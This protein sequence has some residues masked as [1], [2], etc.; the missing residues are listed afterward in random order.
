MSNHRSIKFGFDCCFPAVIFFCALLCVPSIANSQ[1]VF[2]VSNTNDSGTGSL[3]Q[4][5]T[6]ANTTSNADAN[7]PDMIVFDI[8]S[9]GVQTIVTSSLPAIYDPVIID[10]TTQPGYSGVPIV[11]VNGSHTAIA[12]S[13]TGGNT[14]IRGLVIEDF[15][16]GIRMDNFGANLIE[17]NYVGTDVTGSLDRAGGAQ[18]VSMRFNSHGNTVRNN[19]ISGFAEGITVQ[20]SENTI[21]DNFVGTDATGQF[22]IPNTIGIRILDDGQSIGTP[23]TSNLV[24]GNLVSG[25]SNIHFFIHGNA[26]GNLF[27]ENLVGTDLTGTLVLGNT[28]VAGFRIILALDNTFEG[29][30]VGGISRGFWLSGAQGTRIVENFIG[31]DV[32]GEIDLGNDYAITIQNGPDSNTE[33]VSNVIAYNQYAGVMIHNGTAAA[34]NSGNRIQANSIYSNSGLGIDLTGSIGV[35]PNDDGDPDTGP[36][37]LQ[38]FP[39]L[40]VVE[41]GSS[42]HVVGVL[43]SMPSQE[44]EIEFFASSSVDPSGH[45]EGERFLG[46]IVVNTDATN[47]ASFD[48]MLPEASFGV[49]WIT[50]TATDSQGNTSEFSASL[51]I[52]NSAPIANAGLDQFVECSESGNAVVALDGTG[53]FDPDGNSLDYLW[54]VPAGIVLDDET[55]ATPSGLFPLGITLVT[56]TVSDGKG[57]VGVN[58]VEITVT[59]EIP[60]EVSCTTDLMLLWPPNHQM[61]DVAVFIDATDDCSAPEDLILL[62]VTVSSSE[63]DDSNGT[64]DG[65]TIGDV[66]GENGDTEPVNV[67]SLFGYNAMTMSFEGSLSLRAERDGA[68]SGRTYTISA[69]LLDTANNLAETSCVIVVPHDRRGKK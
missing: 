22:A 27:T 66:N 39:I 25:N 21:G 2:T 58:D 15:S 12:F 43:N 55:S 69:I 62:S 48:A 54:S 45:G 50:A 60:P 31:T 40:T 53:S 17:A 37:N 41:G 67:T 65:E 16:Y 8:G 38:N 33:I 36:N 52:T 9:G 7:T 6:D 42:T 61:E 18:G 64:G 47:Q 49:E 44:F 46:R 23:V 59:D 57:G 3:K 28:N 32:S 14:T 29:N 5:I 1:T 10:G 30:V 26:N 20:T 51:Q 56:L 63:L 34:G 24:S 35:T 68:G 4:A 19:L 11:V 13:I